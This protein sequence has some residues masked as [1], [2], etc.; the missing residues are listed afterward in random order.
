MSRT[1][2]PN[3]VLRGLGYWFFYGR[4]KLGPWIEASTD[5]TQRP[6]LHPASATASPVLALLS[7]ALVRWR[8]RVVLHRCS[9]FVGVVIAVGAHPYDSPTPFGAV[10]KQLAHGLDGRVRAAQHRPRDA[11]RRPRARRC[12]SAR[13]STRSSLAAAPA[14]A[15]R[16]AWSHRR[17]LRRRAA[18]IVNLPALWNG[19]F[20]GKNLQR[21]EEIP[22]YW[23]DAATYLD[24]QA[25]R[26]PGA[27]AARL[28]L[29]VVPVGA[30]PSTR[31]RPGSWTGP[32]S[33]AS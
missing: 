14:S 11:A 5:Y 12:C 9:P 1:S 10:F 25:A 13:A 33:R 4:D 19:T 3:E 18:C 21:P 29:R 16:S 7:A 32:T 22:Q 26:H 6:V 28:R 31:S 8:H 23:K 24:A 15:R 27:R 17:S 2:L 20:Y 30:T